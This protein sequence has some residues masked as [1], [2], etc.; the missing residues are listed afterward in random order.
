MQPSECGWMPV[1]GDCF[2]KNTSTVGAW[3]VVWLLVGIIG[4]QVMWVHAPI[5]ISGLTEHDI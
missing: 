3:I 4:S 1:L 2:A 5:S